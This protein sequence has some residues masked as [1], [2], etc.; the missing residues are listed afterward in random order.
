VT[1]QRD[2]RD[3][4]RDAGRSVHMLQQDAQ[5]IETGLRLAQQKF[6]SK[7]ALSGPQDFQEK[8]ARIAAEAGLKVEFSDQRLNKIM[9]DRRAELDA[10]KARQAEARKLAQDFAKQREQEKAKAKEPAST[11][12][13]SEGP[14]TARA[15]HREQ[16]TKHRTQPLHRRGGSHRRK[17]CVPAAGRDVIRHDRKQFNEAPQP[18]DQVQVTYRQGR[19]PLKTWAE[20]RDRQRSFARPVTATNYGCSDSRLKTARLAISGF[21]DSDYLQLTAQSDSHYLQMNLQS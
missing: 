21:S 6:G 20:S 15:G 11:C 1:Y 12:S 13:A 16:G 17:A 19:R 5:T 3:M 10:E 2:G 14:G 9:Q 7:L 18:G 8:A 4:L